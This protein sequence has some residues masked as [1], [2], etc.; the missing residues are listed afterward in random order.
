M[1]I[2]TTRGASDSSM[3]PIELAR[4]ARRLGLSAVVVT[5]HDRLWDPLEVVR[6]REERSLLLINGMEVTTDLGHVLVLGVHAYLPAMRFARELRRIVSDANGYMIAA[7]PFRHQFSRVE[8]ERKGLEPRDLT[9]AEASQ[10]PLLN[11]V[12]AIEVLNGG[13]SLEENILALEVAG[14][15]GKPGVAGS[16][17]HSH[18]GIGIHTTVFERTLDSEADLLRELHAGRFYPANGLLQG[19]MQPFTLPAD[20]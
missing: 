5:E 8:W 10:S 2:H 13:N 6:F 11:L 18:Q 4:V 12:D 19:D 20:L 16:D 1:H 15:L 17:A 9:A 14:V 7:H 3:R